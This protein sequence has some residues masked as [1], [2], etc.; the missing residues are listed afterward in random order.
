MTSRSAHWA[1][2]R[3]P[4]FR[5]SAAVGL[6]FFLLLGRSE[7]S[8]VYGQ[9]SSQEESQVTCDKDLT[10]PGHMSDIVSNAL[11]RG[12]EVDGN[13]VKAFLVDA[14]ETYATGDEVLS[15]A[16][17]HFSIE[18]AVLR[19]QV[20]AFAHVNCVHGPVGGADNGIRDRLTNAEAEALRAKAA[21]PVIV[22]QFAKDVIVHVVLHEM[23]HALVREFDLPV[24]SNEETL[25]DAFATH[26]LTTYLPDRA[27][28]VLLARVTSLMIEAAEVPRVE[29]T[30]AGE[31]NS[32]ARRAYQ[33]AAVAMAADGEKYQAVAAAA[34]MSES[35]VRKA[36]DYGTE[37]HRS[38]RRLLKPFWTSE[39]ARSNE[40][41]LTYEET[42]LFNG[43]CGD[44]V[45][46]ELESALRGVDWHSTVTIKFQ[47]GQGTAGWSRSARTITVY[48]EY[49]RRFIRQGELA[50]KGTIEPR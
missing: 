47:A 7:S 31:H 12:C 36:R 45:A 34:G 50:A 9:E 37:I 21:E 39:G 1:N 20:N 49:A 10:N 42:P 14:H 27:E 29:W 33:I 41:R 17:K 11:A 4:L 3:T 15:A 43:L 18:E 8:S 30:V 40:A 32:D 2:R 25:A 6:G 16:A 13:K 44:G 48:G 24:L 38:W 5:T 28:A 19:H 23:A 22:N 26:Y 46:A 35:D